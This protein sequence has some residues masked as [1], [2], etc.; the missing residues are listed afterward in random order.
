MGKENHSVD[1]NDSSI[2]MKKGLS[3]DYNSVGYEDDNHPISTNKASEKLKKD[4]GL[5]YGL[6]RDV[7]SQFFNLTLQT[8]MGN[9]WEP[10]ENYNFLIKENE[11]FELT[12]YRIKS[13][14]NKFW[15]K[16]I[17]KDKS[18]EGIVLLIPSKKDRK[19]LYQ[20]AIKLKEKRGGSKLPNPVLLQFLID[21]LGHYDKNHRGIHR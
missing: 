1:T 11:T 3:I 14:I 18:F 5:D 21:E 12:K 7:V 16:D 20:N 13:K 8:P 6:G 2:K 15:F 9:F 10:K 17:K 4:L 19:K